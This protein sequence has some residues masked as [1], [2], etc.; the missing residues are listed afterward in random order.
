MTY[1][2]VHC[3]DV[4]LETTFAEL[5]G[6]NARR[7]ALADAFVRIVDLALERRADALTIGGDLY[8]AERAGPQTARLLFEQFARFGKPVF[9]APG[10][11]DPHS[12]TALTARDDLP[13]NVRV[14][15]EATW[16]AIPLAEGITLFGYGHTPAEPGRPF[17]GAR[18]ERG[19]VQLALVHGSDQ[20]RC[21]P[22]KRVTAAFTQAEVE[23]A[24]ATLLL[25]GHFHGGYI[26]RAGGRPIFGYPGSPEPIKFGER[27]E[28]GV[29]VVTIEGTNV[30][31]EAVPIARTRLL[32]RSV[33][34]GGVTTEQ[35]AFDRVAVQL[36]DC[37]ANDYV[38]L[39]LTG[40]VA[41][42]TR[43]D[44]ALMAEQFGATLGALE[45]ADESVAYDYAAIAR[46]PTVR[47]RVVADL[48]AQRAEPD[49]ERAAQA[50]RA[51]RYALAAFEGAEIAP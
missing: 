28:H 19:G 44:A 30:E 42:G 46:E 2:I 15:N 13:P 26:A 1:T 43:I 6:G 23:A 38:R 35:A 22:N 48:L 16:S 17:A 37:G 8:E 9:I 50:G 10:N 36:A 33:D 7:K 5:R 27:G 51:L 41:Y 31:A 24:G 47:G 21:P 34:L 11:H 45:I 32:E 20:D 18:F 25:T 40:E 29:L 12:S 49:T 3:A 4:H 14:F 39:S